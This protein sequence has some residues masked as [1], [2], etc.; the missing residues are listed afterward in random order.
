LEPSALRRK[1]LWGTQRK[2]QAVLSANTTMELAGDLITP[3]R[4]GFSSLPPTTVQDGGVYPPHVHEYTWTFQA[5]A[6]WVSK[7]GAPVHCGSPQGCSHNQAYPRTCTDT[8]VVV[9]Y[10]Q[11]PSLPWNLA[12]C[13][14]PK[15]SR[16]PPCMHEDYTPDRARFC[17]APTSTCVT[18]REPRVG[19]PRTSLRVLL[20]VWLHQEHIGG[21]IPGPKA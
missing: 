3:T 14:Q 6:Q 1:E 7:D 4:R 11:V 21:S 9:N 15:T 17:P 13:S 20:V 5:E 16:E 18:A 12:F 2:S 8:E 19:K 10:T